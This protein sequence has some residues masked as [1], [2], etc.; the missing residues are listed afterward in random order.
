MKTIIIACVLSA[1]IGGGC[2]GGI[3][4][5]AGSQDDRFAKAVVERAQDA[6]NTYRFGERFARL[7]EKVNGIEREISYIREDLSFLRKQKEGG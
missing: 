4:Y 5:L 1:L 7:E 3:V 2:G 6:I